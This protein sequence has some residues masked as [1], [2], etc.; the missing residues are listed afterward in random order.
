MRWFFGMWF[1]AIDGR[2]FAALWMTGFFWDERLL[3]DDGVFYFL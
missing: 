3:W 1:G 2:S